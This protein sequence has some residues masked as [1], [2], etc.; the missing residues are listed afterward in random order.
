MRC[1]DK[2]QHIDPYMEPT[3]H[4]MFSLVSW[5]K[6]LASLHL[7]TVLNCGK[8]PVVLA[9]H[10][11]KTQRVNMLKISLDISITFFTDFKNVRITSFTNYQHRYDTYFTASPYLKKTN[12][13]TGMMMPVH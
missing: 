3:F 10:I 11:A 9:V 4:V 5:V 1:R 7:Y 6:I 8:K 12:E 13:L 2:N